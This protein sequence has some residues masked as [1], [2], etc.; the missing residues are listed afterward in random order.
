M[1]LP[2]H[3]TEPRESIA[4]IQTAR[5]ICRACTE[6][7]HLLSRVYAFVTI[8][9]ARPRLIWLTTVDETGVP[10]SLPL[11]FL[12]DEAHSTFLIYSMPEADRDH[13]RHLRQNPKVC[14]HFDFEVSSGTPI[15][16][17]GEVSVSTADPPSDQIPAW[18]EKYQSL[19]SQMGMTLQQAAAIA[20]VAL[21][22]RPL[23]MIVTS[24]TT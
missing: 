4:G 23:T 16:L 1:E 15:V 6:R 21:R 7:A 20:P 11:A 13:M 17:T 18:V 22:V 2:M 10:H 12:W 8:D 19:F 14:L 5:Q 24:W 3:H 9:T